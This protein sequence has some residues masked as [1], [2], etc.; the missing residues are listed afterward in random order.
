MT[1]HGARQRL[2]T[3][4]FAWIFLVLSLLLLSMAPSPKWIMPLLARLHHTSPAAV[5]ALHAHLATL[6][7]TSG[8]L[9][10]TLSAACFFWRDRLQTLCSRGVDILAFLERGFLHDEPGWTGLTY[11][12]LAGWCL[13]TTTL[14]IALYAP[15]LQQGFFQFDDFEIISVMRTHPLREAIFMLH[16]DHTMPLFRLEVSLMHALFGL[17]AF[18]YNAALLMMLGVLLLFG[19]L[20]LKEMAAG[21]VAA[22]LFFVLAGTALLW[23]EF[24]A[25]Y[26]ATSTYL[27][28]TALC[29]IACWAYLRW[30]RTHRARFAAAAVVS[31]L[32]AALLDISGFWVTGGLAVFV[33]AVKIGDGRGGWSIWW[34]RHRSMAAGLVLACA[35]VVL[36]NACVF[37]LL[38]PQGFLSMSGTPPTWAQRGEQMWYYTSTV[39]LLPLIPTGYWKL[40]PHFLAGVLLAVDLAALALMVT[41]RRLPR[42]LWWLALA[43]LV[44]AIGNGAM[45]ALGRPQLGLSFPWQTKYIGSGYTWWLVSLCVLAGA[46][47]K[48]APQLRR[49]TLLQWYSAA[50][51]IYIMLQIIGGM[52][53]AAITAQAAGYPGYIAQAQLRRQGIEQLRAAIAPLFFS[54][55]VPSIPL[56]TGR[57]IEARY[58]ALF[59]YDLICYRDFI[60][61]PGRHARFV[62][63]QA[64]ADNS[65]G[66]RDTCWEAQQG[67]DPLVTV[68]S[69]RDAAGEAFRRNLRDNA[70]ARAFYLAPVALSF[71]ATSC[72]FAGASSVSDGGA[73]SVVRSDEWDP[74]RAHLLHVT[75]RYEGSSPVARIALP[76]K[77][78][79]P[80]VAPAWLDIPANQTLCLSV[81]LLQLH[82]YALSRQ[83]H[84]LRMHFVT[85]GTYLV[86]GLSLGG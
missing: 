85:P 38:A 50:A 2:A 31:P 63:N 75:M 41:A 19:V 34:Y 66:D 76:F 86:K 61:P 42:A 10:L 1:T 82:S 17:H 49:A 54:Q 12:Q 84:D 78:E 47:W 39:L 29:V 35:A 18:F 44:I 57:F 72:A 13:A 55:D 3:P 37:L 81:D 46:V 8:V 79:F 70:Q 56:L 7:A 74:E 68:T 48:R 59:R 6:L 25:G 83:V 67:A 32:L 30:H 40:P 27:Q 23:G 77:S 14:L 80:S 65:M 33:L 21:F 22:A 69:L 71:H 45:V 73:S 43:G 52:A 64:M 51:V 28:Q 4:P 16:G 26:Y 53:A 15:T 5:M 62:Q 24:L 11:V 58:P 60:Q 9:C 36:F 20:L